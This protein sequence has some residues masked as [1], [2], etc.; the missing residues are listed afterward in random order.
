MPIALVTGAQQGIGA[1]IAEALARDGAD[2]AL[3]WLDDGAAAERGAAAIRA[4]GRRAVAI[5]ADVGTPGGRAALQ[6]GCESALGV[7]DILVCNAG[8]FPRADFLSV[9]EAEWD[10]VLGINLKAVAFQAQLFA[11]ALG[12]GG[13]GRPGVILTLSSSATRGDPRG[14]AYSAS[15]AGLLGLTRSLALALAPAIRVNCIAPG[16]TDTAQPRGA[17]TEAEL[18]ARAA[19]F[20]IPRIGTPADIGEL[21][22]F[23]CSPRAAWITGQLHHVN[24]GM[25]MP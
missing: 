2:V 3:N 15:K 4:L 8:I 18:H 12:Q 9:T 14:V 1:A 24:G 7:P 5:Q 10:S 11:R 25:W 20:P 6:A 16:L 13:A 21:A 17:A 23:L 22:A 19:G